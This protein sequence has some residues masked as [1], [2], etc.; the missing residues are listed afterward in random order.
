[1][2]TKYIWISSFWAI[3]SSKACNLNLYIKVLLP[4]ATCSLQ[5]FYTSS[6][7]NTSTESLEDASWG[8]EIDN[9]NN[10]LLFHPGH[11]HLKPGFLQ[12]SVW[13]SEHVI[14]LDVVVYS[15]NVSSLG[16]EK[17]DYEFKVSLSYKTA[18]KRMY[19][20]HILA[21]VHQHGYLSSVQI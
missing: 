13:Q 16:P 20:Q 11:S 17:E 21:L 15:C 6:C 9:T 7:P 12:I 18:S 3:I 1:M 10:T 14:R 19:P 4:Q 8:V 5:V 2:S